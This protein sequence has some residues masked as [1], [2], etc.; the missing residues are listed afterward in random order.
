MNLKELH[1]FDPNTKDQWLK[2][3]QKE[4]GERSLESLQWSPEPGIEM[5]P[6]YTQTPNAAE[7]A[8]GVFPFHIHQQVTADGP[9]AARAQALMCLAGGAQSIG[10]LQAPESHEMDASLAEIEWPYI[11]L[12]WQNWPLTMSYAETLHQ[13]VDQRG[14]LSNTLQG[15]LGNEASML[16]SDNWDVETVRYYQK[17]FPR[18]RL[19]YIDGVALAR[20]GASAVMQVAAILA[21]AQEALHRLISAGFTI[22]E[23][24]AMLQIQTS[25]DTSYFLEITK[26]RVIRHLYAELV[27]NYNPEHACSQSI[28]I[29]AVTGITSYATT[30]TNTNLLR[31]TTAAMSAAIGQASSIEVQ[32][33]DAAADPVQSMRWARNI[34]HLLRE[35]SYM[36][37]ALHAAQGSYYLEH[38]FSQMATQAWQSL[39]QM[40]EQ[41]GWT[42]QASEWMNAAHAM[43]ASAEQ[44]IA[45]GQKIRVGVNKYQAKGNAKS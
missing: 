6:Y 22:D 27:A 34:L 35:E 3:I 16:W 40:E 10:F 28:F 5:E 42:V 24:S 33:H 26:I 25:A 38:M 36:D 30:D 19:F 2:A 45:S 7:S 14:W 43:G 17:A 44:A 12:H 1:V 21:Q 18:C 9:E 8:L 13:Y 37:S 32:P 20:T 41:G 4:L 31:A 23:A 39:V 29:H 11:Q 15:L